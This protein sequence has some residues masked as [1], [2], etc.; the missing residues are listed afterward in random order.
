MKKAAGLLIMTAAL[1]AAMPDRSIVWIYAGW[2][3]KT[4]KHFFR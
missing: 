3:F 4:G 1:I 2:N